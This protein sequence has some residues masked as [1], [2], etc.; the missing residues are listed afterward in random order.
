VQKFLAS[1]MIKMEEQEEGVRGRIGNTKQ[2]KACAELKPYI[3][4]ILANICFAGFN[5]VSKV[6][7]DKGMSRYVLV[8]YGHAF[9]TLATALLAFLFERLPF[10]FYCS[11][12][13]ICYPLSFFHHHISLTL[14]LGGGKGMEWKKKEEYFKNIL[15]FPLFRSLNRREW[16]GMERPFPCLGV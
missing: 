9:G 15:S 13:I 4:C 5:I 10:I 7:L 6:S 12:M 1:T 11:V 2:E 3:Y 8:A 16:K 14:R